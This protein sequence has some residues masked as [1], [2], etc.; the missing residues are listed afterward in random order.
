MDALARVRRRPSR[1]DGR[2]RQPQ[3]VPADG[4]QDPRCTG[5]APRVRRPDP[6]RCP[7]QL[8]DPRRRPPA[9]G[10]AALRGPGEPGSRWRLRERADDHPRRLH[11]PGG[12]A[13]DPPVPRGARTSPGGPPPS[14]CWR[15]RRSGSRSRRTACSRRSAAWALAALAAA[16][17]SDPPAR[18][19][20]LG[21]AGRP[22]ARLVPAAVLRP[23]PARPARRRGPP[24][25]PVRGALSRRS[26]WARSCRCWCSRLLRFPAVGGVPRPARP[27][28]GG[29]RRRSPGFV[30]VLGRPRRTGHRRR[31][32]PGCRPR[33][34]SRLPAGGHR[35]SYA[36]WSG[37]PRSRSW[38]R[39][40][41]R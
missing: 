34:R 12:R 33:A 14:W 40:P 20:G 39:T 15:R 22:A 32:G 37:R 10:A 6:G 7:G 26:Q 29:H 18:V 19:L 23:A 4:P 1:P 11:D 27:L 28:L 24:R 9:G 25:R 3:R 13:R 30:L 2:D 8:G 16:A 38:L 17:R 31:S 21:P 36:C 35:A 5:D 41:P